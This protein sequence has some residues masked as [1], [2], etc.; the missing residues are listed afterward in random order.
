VANKNDLTNR[1][2]IL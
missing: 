2:V 1:E